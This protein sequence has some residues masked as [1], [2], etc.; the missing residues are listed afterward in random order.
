MGKEI[1]K[2]TSLPPDACSHAGNIITEVGNDWRNWNF[3]AGLHLACGYKKSAKEDLPESTGCMQITGSQTI[4][5]ALSTEQFLAP[6]LFRMG[7][8]QLLFAHQHCCIL[9]LKLRHSSSGL[10]YMA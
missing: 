5:E 6:G 9:L 4:T 8:S 1:Y 10:E 7:D 2:Y 3:P